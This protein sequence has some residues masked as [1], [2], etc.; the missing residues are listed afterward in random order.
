[1]HLTDGDLLGNDPVA[2]ALK[3]D[4]VQEIVIGSVDEVTLGNAVVVNLNVAD[5]FSI[6]NIAALNVKYILDKRMSGWVS[7]RALPVEAESAYIL[8]LKRDKVIVP[9]AS[10]NEGFKR[11]S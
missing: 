5:G 7:S 9:L 4:A 1:M 6:I 2:Q 8:A 10:P 3:G 11:K